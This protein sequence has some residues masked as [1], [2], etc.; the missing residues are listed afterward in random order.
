MPGKPT[1]DGFGEGL[2]ELARTNKDVV[3]LAGD[4][5]GSTRAEWF[6]AKYP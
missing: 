3:V 6:A 5:A 2:L 4:L 1:R